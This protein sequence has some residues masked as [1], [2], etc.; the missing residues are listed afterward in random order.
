[1]ILFILTLRY[2]MII[3]LLSQPILTSN[4]FELIKAVI[5]ATFITSSIAKFD[6]G[7]R[8][9]DSNIR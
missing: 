9:S 8:Q 2:F 3:S 5:T 7:V 6:K 4:E 1:M